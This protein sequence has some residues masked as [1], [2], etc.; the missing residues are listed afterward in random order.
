MVPLLLAQGAWL[1][2]VRAAAAPVPHL[3]T[4]EAS[5]R[6]GPTL[7]LTVRVRCLHPC[8]PHG[9]FSPLS[10]CAPLAWLRP[11]SGCLPTLWQTRI[12][13]ALL[14]WLTECLLL[15]LSVAVCVIVLLL[16]L[17][18]GEVPFMAGGVP[19]LLLWV[20]IIMLL[21]LVKLLL[22]NG[23]QRLLLQ[24]LLADGL[25][26]VLLLVLLLR[27]RSRPN[28][29]GHVLVRVDMQRQTHA[30]AAA[31]SSTAATHPRRPAASRRPYCLPRRSP[32]TARPHALLL[33]KTITMPTV[34]GQMLA[35]LLLAWRGRCKPGLVRI[36]V[37]RRT[38]AVDPASASSSNAGA[39]TRRRAAPRTPY[40]LQMLTV[41]LLMTWRGRCKPDRVRI[42]VRRHTHAAA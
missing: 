27:W 11:Y 28:R 8:M 39:H 19:Q 13:L 4:E 22:V 40:C 7:W 26:E 16:L 34:V 33:P 20:M 29:C 9:P 30:A 37:R 31:A 36:Q 41:L 24:L 35:V 38:R 17:L 25:V 12:P 15:V 14:L 10:S 6:T 32:G 23:L 21:L 1:A 3:P 5:V 2:L 18:L 42:R